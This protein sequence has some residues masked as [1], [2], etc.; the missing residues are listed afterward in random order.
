MVYCLLPPNDYPESMIGE[1]HPLGS[2][3]Y[4]RYLK[5]EVLPLDFHAFDC[6]KFDQKMEKLLKYDLLDS[7]ASAPIVSPRLRKAIEA[8]ASDVVQFLPAKLV[9]SDGETE[10]YKVMNPVCRVKAVDW[11]NSKPRF[12]TDEKTII[13][14]YWLDYLPDDQIEPFTI[15]LDDST[16]LGY[17]IVSDTMKAALDWGKFKGLSLRR[18]HEIAY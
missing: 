3:D 7:S 4:I 10:E 18:P 1:H 5:G 16:E 17:I 6:V 15:A 12:M 9:A 2:A 11:N 13:G 8:L 14:F